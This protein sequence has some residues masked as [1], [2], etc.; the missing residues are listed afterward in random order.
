VAEF[1]THAWHC[2][3]RS[4]RLMAFGSSSMTQ[5]DLGGAVR[6]PLKLFSLLQGA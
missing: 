2:Q 4:A 1:R 3:P 6:L 5:Q